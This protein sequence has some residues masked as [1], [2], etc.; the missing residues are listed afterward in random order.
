VDETKA[1]T[2][3]LAN[4]ASD[5]HICRM[6]ELEIKKQRMAFEAEGKHLEAEERLTAARHQ[7]EHEKEKHDLEMLHLQLQ[8]QGAG[9]PGQPAAMGQFGAE[10][11]SAEPFAD[12]SAF[13]NL[14]MD[15]YNM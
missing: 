8:Y 9:I 6:A 2:M 12:S 4:L 5:K 13:G 1:E 15:N 7:C 3:A 11:F 14:G 10:T